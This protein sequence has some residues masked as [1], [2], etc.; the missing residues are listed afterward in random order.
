MGARQH[1][2]VKS[3][4]D[5]RFMERLPHLRTVVLLAIPVMVLATVGFARAGQTRDLSPVSLAGA[6]PA[7]LLDGAATGIER[8]LAK[9][10]PGFGFQVVSRSTLHAKP[11]GPQIQVPDATDPSKLAGLADRLYLGASIAAGSARPDGF[12][13]QMRAGPAEDAGPDFEKAEVTLAGLQRGTELW[14]NDGEGWYRTDQLPGIGLDPATIARLPTLLR[15]AT[16]P[17]VSATTDPD[18]RTVATVAAGGTIADAPGLMAID[19]ASFSELTGPLEYGLDEGGR[20]VAL[21]ATLRNT[22]VEGFDLIVDT[23]ISLTYDPPPGA[24]PE[25]APRLPA[26]SGG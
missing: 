9:G 17:Q 1:V 13:L 6:A 10:G 18:G 21:H 26:A 20:L 24:L 11:D 12:W 2:S 5:A 4:P 25:P 3:T 7:A 22:R 14:R 16:D 15:T 8:V 19:A 23:R